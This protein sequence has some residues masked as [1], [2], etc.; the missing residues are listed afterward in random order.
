MAATQTF[1]ITDAI[2]VCNGDIGL[3]KHQFRSMIEE[4]PFLVAADGG[5]NRLRRWKIRPHLMIGDLDSVIPL[6]KRIFSDVETIF[7]PDQ[8]STDLEKALDYLVEHHY[9]RAAV[10]G[11]TGNQLDHTLANISILLKYRE[12]IDLVLKDAMFDIF[13]AGREKT[14]PA[15]VG[16]RI[17]LMP[18][19]FCRGIVTEGLKYPLK[20]EAM[21]FGVREGVSNEA[22]ADSVTVRV[23]EGDLLMMVQREPAPAV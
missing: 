20:N 10:F 22:V 15:R 3:T 1:S 16:Q 23:A 7:L 2:V 17:S 14:I 18:A 8:D 21:E 4:D 12:R 9:K 13:F 5:A 11:A 6:T 19:C